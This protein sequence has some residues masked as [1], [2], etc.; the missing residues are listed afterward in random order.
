M[1]R[2]PSSPG[3]ALA[4]ILL[5]LVA[6]PT[7]RAADDRLA[8]E[9]AVAGRYLY[10]TSD[11]YTGPPASGY[12]QLPDTSAAGK[13]VE[14]W[15]TLVYDT[16]QND[17]GVLISSLGLRTRIDCATHQSSD[18]VVIMMD[19]DNRLLGAEWVNAD[20]E[21]ANPDSPKRQVMDV[22]CDGQVSPYPILTGFAAVRADAA[23][24]AAAK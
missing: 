20:S 2:R 1:I 17:R 3:M 7:A 19:G 21:Y 16:P 15:L 11:T 14:V 4:A 5:S 6:A 18:L 24:R 23:R 8:P 10:Q 12:F 13:T 9:F 22:I